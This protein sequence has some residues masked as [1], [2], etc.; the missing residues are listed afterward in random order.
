MKLIDSGVFLEHD[1]WTLWFLQYLSRPSPVHV[2]LGTEQWNSSRGWVL[3]FR[4]YV[5]TESWT[6]PVEGWLDGKTHLYLWFR[7]GPVSTICTDRTPWDDG[8]LG[9]WRGDWRRLLRQKLESAVSMILWVVPL[10]W[11]ESHSLTADHPFP[12]STPSL[13]GPKF[14][15]DLMNDL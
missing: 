15:V 12:F 11:R 3:T 13:F 7:S 5:E 2:F 10:W 4:L 8:H 1:T 9:T 14:R 6:V